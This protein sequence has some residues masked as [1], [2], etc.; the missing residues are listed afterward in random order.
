MPYD[1]SNVTCSISH[2]RRSNGGVKLS[3]SRLEIAVPYLTSVSSGAR[4][5]AEHLDAASSSSFMASPLASMSIR[6]GP[7][8]PMSKC[9]CVGGGERGREG[10]EHDQMLIC[11]R[12]TGN[13]DEYV[14]E[15]LITLAHHAYFLNHSLGQSIRSE[16]HEP[17]ETSSS[18]MLTSPL[19]LRLACWP[20][21]VKCVSVLRNDG[22][23]DGSRLSPPALSTTLE[24]HGSPE[25]MGREGLPRYR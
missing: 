19:T 15:V 22:S 8:L 17:G 9:V 6:A 23:N 11:N 13:S 5:G 24:P 12:G 18:V 21:G 14:T 10:S 16:S 3:R 4:Y 20:A 7:A 25:V 2:H 1:K